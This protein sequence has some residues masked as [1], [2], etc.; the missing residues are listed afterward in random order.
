MDA[1]LKMRA[2]D[3]DRQQVVDRLRGAVA[4]GRLTVDE[5]VDRMGRAYQA[6]TYG[7][8]APLHA[9]LPADGA[10]G[11][12][13]ERAAPVPAGARLT[14][15]AQRG[16][17][18]GLPVVLRVLWTIWLTAL[19]VNVVVW[20]LVS[21]TSG[22]LAYPWPLWVAGPWGAVL[23]AKSIAA[24]QLRRGRASSAGCLSPRNG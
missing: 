24:T 18:A 8:L 20:A 11:L 2:S 22:H 13:A 6:V 23:F 21:V 12:V 17:L 3:H 9:D 19:S 14:G 4:D 5:Y 1:Q 10:V 16:I 7:D 15:D